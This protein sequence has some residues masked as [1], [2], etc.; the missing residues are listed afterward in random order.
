MKHSQEINSKAWTIR[1]H[2][3]K[4]FNCKIM[5]VS[6]K[7]CLRMAK[8]NSLSY[9]NTVTKAYT[10]SAS[11]EDLLTVNERYNPTLQTKRCPALLPLA[12]AFDKYMEA[13]GKPN[14]IYRSDDGGFPLEMQERIREEILIKKQDNYKKIIEEMRY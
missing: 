13:F 2:A 5:E 11:F 8:E 1:K 3:A 14:R 4:R 6:W 10:A 12:N 9:L 7:E